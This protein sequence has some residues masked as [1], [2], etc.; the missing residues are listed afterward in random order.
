[1]LLFR[2][3]EALL[4]THPKTL[5]RDTSDGFDFAGLLVFAAFGFVLSHEGSSAETRCIMAVPGPDIVLV[6]SQVLM[7]QRI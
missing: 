3:A 5:S 1:V 7:I 6:T 2:L 4:S